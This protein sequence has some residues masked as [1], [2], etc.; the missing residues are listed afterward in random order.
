[1]TTPT[2]ESRL[3]AAW[4]CKNIGGTLG[5]P[6]E[7]YT[8]TLHLC[9]YDPVPTE[10][11]PNDDL[12]L[13]LAWLQLLRTNGLF[14]TPAHF[15]RVWQENI[16]YHI[17]EYSLAQR[18]IARGLLPPVTGAHDNWYRAGMGATIR[19]EIWSCLAPG[20]PLLAALYSYMDGS[21]DHAGDG[22]YAEVFFAVLESLAFV[23]SSPRRLVEE[24]LRYIPAHC[25]IARAVRM[26]VELHDSGASLHSAR[27]ALCAQFAHP[28]DFTHSPLNLAFV[29]L[30]MMYGTDF[31]SAVC[32]AVNCGY[33]TDCTA[34]SV[35]S[36]FGIAHG[37]EAIPQ[38]WIAPVGEDIRIGWGIRGIDYPPTIQALCR[39]IADLRIA[40]SS[41]REELVDHL[42]RWTG[43]RPLESVEGSQRIE[44]PPASR[45]T[46]SSTPAMTIRWDYG[47]RPVISPSGAISGVLHFENHAARAQPVAGSIVTPQ[48]DLV[49]EFSIDPV[50]GREAT[51]P[52]KASARLIGCELEVHLRTAAPEPL[53]RVVYQEPRIW[54]VLELSMEDREAIVAIEHAGVLAGEQAG[55]STHH[56][57]GDSITGLLPPA[58]RV[59]FAQV[60]LAAE[61]DAVMRLVLNSTGPVHAWLNGGLICA[62]PHQS[63]G[64]APSAHL[65]RPNPGTPEVEQNNGFADVTLPAGVSTLLLRLDASREPADAIIHAMGLEVPVDGPVTAACFKPPAADPF[66]L[67]A[68]RLTTSSPGN[69]RS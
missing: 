60:E 65:Q 38:E 43:I 20:D 37:E 61:S 59:R 8:G 41:R 5:A 54:K 6:Y 67:A 55:T 68:S 56:L 14:L 42:L 2:Y 63:M 13:Q 32:A 21:V 35:A 29:I 22:V 23:E 44:Y 19:T 1:M 62:K 4:L 9:Y 50:A 69:A 7:G 34:A 25:D 66:D 27:A 10:S 17:S 49:R 46:L 45:V 47:G 40:V 3:R 64:F 12:D 26:A 36:L 16:T 51:V 28:A 52:V 31:A 58:G 30:G 18:N 11:A 39:E 15:A 24:A 57:D 48:G 33:D 53:P